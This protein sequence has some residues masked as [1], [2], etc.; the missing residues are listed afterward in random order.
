MLDP[1]VV[2]CNVWVE[3]RL[4]QEFTS[5]TIALADDEVEDDARVKM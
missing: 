1:A 4:R 3:F 2:W 5:N